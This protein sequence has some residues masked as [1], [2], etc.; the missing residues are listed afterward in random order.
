M[1]R[2]VRIPRN[3]GNPF[4]VRAGGQEYKYAADSVVT[5]P[6]AVADV[7][8]NINRLTPQADP[9]AEDGQ[10]CTKSEV[11]ALIAAAMA[12]GGKQLP[13]VSA[14]DNGK[15]AGVDNGAWAVI[16]APS[17]LPEVSG[18]DNGKLMGVDNG[19]WA[20]VV[21]PSGLPSVTGSDNGKVLGVSEGQWGPVT[22]DKPPIVVPFTLTIDSGT[23]DITV[24]TTADFAETYAAFAERRPLIAAGD[25]AAGT[26]TMRLSGIM[27]G[28]I[29]DDDTKRKL[30]VYIPTEMGQGYGMYILTWTASGVVPNS[31]QLYTTS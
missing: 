11:K 8:D 21:A 30:V 7:V 27:L 31:V 2:Q 23:G 5:V 24:T 17:G 25:L 12:G 22:L 19:V 15:I 28:A 18:S 1:S 10:Y 14:S 6:D 20:A 9:A 29:S 16:S 26:V 4:V 3:C 13:D